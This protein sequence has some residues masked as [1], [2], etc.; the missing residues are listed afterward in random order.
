[1]VNRKVFAALSTLIGIG[2]FCLVFVWVGV[3]EVINAVKILSYSRFLILL[4]FTIFLFFLTAVRWNIILRAMG[5]KTNF[6]K[7]W[8]AKI[9]GYAVS[10]LTPFS[11]LGGEPVRAYVLK[12]ENK[13]GME[14]G[15]ASIVIDKMFEFTV[16]IFFMLWGFVFLVSRY[17]LAFNR[18][19]L[20]FFLT[21]LFIVLLVWFFIKI[22]KHEEFFSKFL[23]IFKLHKMKR[24]KFV[25]ASL[26][27]IE[28]DIAR[29][30]KYNKKGVVGALIITLIIN[31]LFIAAYQLIVLFLGIKISFITAIMIFTLF[32]FSSSAPTPGSLGVYEAGFA[33]VFSILG[34]GA[35]VGVAFALLTRLFELVISGVG[36]GLIAVTGMKVVKTI[37]QNNR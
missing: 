2:L 6:L 13:I 24:F 28:K 37:F 16:A 8:M 9:C 5:E 17:T 7:V 4:L 27:R 20:M 1:M 18:L 3:G 30:F 14:K 36:V 31:T 22:L 21:L 19:F 11:R 32:A 10:Y 29:F 15:L 25:H 34:L 23:R 12:K 35:S 26:Q 33:I